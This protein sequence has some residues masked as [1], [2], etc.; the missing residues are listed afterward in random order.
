MVPA[1]RLVIRATICIIFVLC[2]RPEWVQ[3]LVQTRHGHRV[4]LLRTADYFEL[5]SGE[6][7]GVAT[8]APSGFGVALVVV[9]ATALGDGGGGGRSSLQVSHARCVTEG[10]REGIGLY[11]NELKGIMV[12]RCGFL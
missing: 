5:V 6:S 2:F 1:V 4:L 11:T 7:P 10:I 12:R 9:D 3:L 8:A